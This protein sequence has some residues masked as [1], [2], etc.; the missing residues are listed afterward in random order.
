ME[1]D[2]V[3]SS[4]QEVSCGVPQ[5]SILGQQLFLIY[6]NDMYASLKCRLSLCADDSALFY[7]HKSS[8]VI[9]ERLSGELCNCQRWLVDNR[10]SLHLGK[11][12]CLLFGSKRRLK[13]VDD[14]SLSCEG[15]AIKRVFSVKYLGVRLDVNMSGMD[16]ATELVKKCVGRISFLY[17]NVSLLDSDCRRIL[18]LALIQPY[19]DYCCSSWYS[20]LAAS[21]A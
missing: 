3:R 8:K 1:I 18:C 10:L 13:G 2:G 9:A 4:F 17:R 11:T 6:I 15:T 21:S 19:M 5:G 12:E 20:G 7:S 16:H 14:F